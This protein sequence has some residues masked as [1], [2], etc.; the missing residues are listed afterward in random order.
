[1]P[2][3]LVL[4]TA[5]PPFFVPNLNPAQTTPPLARGVGFAPAILPTTPHHHAILS[6]GLTS[7]CAKLKLALLQT[8][9][10]PQTQPI[11]CYRWLNLGTAHRQDRWA[12]A[13]RFDF[14]LCNMIC[15]FDI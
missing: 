6:H 14:E 4:F 7:V 2:F 1:M 3:H 8:D 15:S 5:E 11:C 10:I 13:R 9:L 12:A